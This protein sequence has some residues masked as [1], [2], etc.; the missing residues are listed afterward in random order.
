MQEGPP[1][2]CDVCAGEGTV[3]C[4]FCHGTGVMQLGDT[5]YCSDTGC[6]VCPV[7]GGDVRSLLVYGIEFGSRWLNKCLKI[8]MASSEA[9]ISSFTQLQ[10][11]AECKHCLG[12]GYRASWLDDPF[13]GDWQVVGK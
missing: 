8:A 1:K 13:Q 4:N 2:Q 9:L 11:Q 3:E 12:S 6:S 5:L 10:G 7:C